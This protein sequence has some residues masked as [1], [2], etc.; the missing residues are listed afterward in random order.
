MAGEQEEEEGDLVDFGDRDR[1]GREKREG[2]NKTLTE[3][4]REED[5]W[6]S[7]SYSFRFSFLMERKAVFRAKYFKWPPRYFGIRIY[8]KTQRPERK[9]PPLFSP[10]G[11]GEGVCATSQ[12][13]T[14]FFFRCRGGD[15][16]SGATGRKER[17]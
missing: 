15:F 7:I 17:V 8:E 11:R 16:R 10:S 9:F 4:L 6:S 14:L 2:K 1:C 13:K 5:R 12:K 3:T